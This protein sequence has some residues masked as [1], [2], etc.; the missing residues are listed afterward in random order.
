MVYLVCVAEQRSERHWWL[1]WLGCSVH[2][3]G[4]NETIPIARKHHLT[5]LIC[6][7]AKAGDCVLD[8]Q[9]S[10]VFICVE[11]VLRTEIFELTTRLYIVVEDILTWFFNYD[12]FS[13]V[14][15]N[16]LT[17]QILSYRKFSEQLTSNVV[18]GWAWDMPLRVRRGINKKYGIILSLKLRD[19]LF[20]VFL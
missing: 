13:F 5:Q 7:E 20:F 6:I 14:L 1:A 11:R 2:V 9:L 10:L 4:A 3:P 18:V 16:Y 12:I 15:D 19:N 17:E 8:L